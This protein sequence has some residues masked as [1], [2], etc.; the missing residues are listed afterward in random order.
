MVQR[1]NTLQDL[2]IS[3]IDLLNFRI[4][5]RSNSLLIFLFSISNI[6]VIIST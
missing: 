6:V 1:K 3:I 2:H 4:V 5:Y